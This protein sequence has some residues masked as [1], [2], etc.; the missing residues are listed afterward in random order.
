M[1]PLRIAALLVGLVLLGACG[2]KD[3]LRDPPAPL[4]DFALG[5]NIVVADQAQ[6]SPVSRDAT[7]E[8]WKVSLQQAIE[9]RFGRYDNSGTKL[10]N[11]GISIDGFALAPPGLPVLLKPRSLLVITANIWDDAAGQKLNTEGKRLIIFENTTGK[12]FIGSGLT[13][14]KAQQMENLSFN[15]A[16]A[17]E[18]WLLDNPEWFGLPP[19]PPQ[20]P[21]VRNGDTRGS[22]IPRAAQ[23]AP[24]G[25]QPVAVPATGP[26]PA[27]ALSVPAA[28]P[29]T[30]P[31]AVAPAAGILPSDVAP[32]TVQ[33]LSPSP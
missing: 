33:P 29:V 20:E 16:K 3:D 2:K 14:S 13:Q 11:L 28:V 9:D 19:K 5:L 18:G 12:T 15:A 6:K 30:V 4:G 1:T 22:S 7:P 27:E 25:A 17:V 32:V 26:V 8:E 31:A 24:A 10:F 23:T 21:T